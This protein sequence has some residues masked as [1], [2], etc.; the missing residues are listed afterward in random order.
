MGENQTISKLLIFYMRLPRTQD[1]LRI[2]VS[3]AILVYIVE[4]EHIV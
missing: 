4:A 1:F 3:L 2:F